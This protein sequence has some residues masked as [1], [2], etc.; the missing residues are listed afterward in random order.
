MLTYG[1][2]S[3]RELIHL[4]YVRK[5]LPTIGASLT[6]ADGG[7]WKK[8][9]VKSFDSQGVCETYNIKQATNKQRLR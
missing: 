4:Q 9:G 8:V 6:G 3:L 1:E 2:T 7:N 5:P